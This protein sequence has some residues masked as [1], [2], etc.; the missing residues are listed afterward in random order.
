MKVGRLNQITE[1]G[2]ANRGDWLARVW[3]ARGKVGA[4]LCRALVMI[5]RAR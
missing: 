4:W 2:E 1:Y 5:R 3:L